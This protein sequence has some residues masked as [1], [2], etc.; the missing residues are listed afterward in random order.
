MQT[1]V[2]HQ[3]K[4]KV[5]SN[6]NNYIFIGQKETSLEHWFWN[7]T[8]PF[9]SSLKHM[10][11][12]LTPHSAF[13]NMQIPVNQDRVCGG[14]ADA[15]KSSPPRSTLHWTSVLSTLYPLEIDVR[16]GSCRRG[17]SEAELCAECFGGLLC[18]SCK[19]CLFPDAAL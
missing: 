9:L 4:S 12:L 17:G 1:K 13:Q 10:C 5:Y 2:A 16:L 7:P 18:V 19:Y 11:R 3:F 15:L 8:S 14:L 6:L